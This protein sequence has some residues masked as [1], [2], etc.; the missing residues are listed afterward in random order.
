[1]VVVWSSQA[2]TLFKSNVYADPS[3][4]QSWPACNPQIFFKWVVSF[5]SRTQRRGITNLISP[6]QPI[7]F[8]PPF[9]SPSP[10]T[11]VAPRSSGKIGGGAAVA[12]VFGMTPRESLAVG[13]LMNTRG[14]VEL[15]ILNIGLDAGVLTEVILADLAL[16]V[17]A[18]RVHG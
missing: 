7:P 12:R 15:I 4:S 8:P 17:L 9:L 11:H 1:M 10:P 2:R 5:H 14:L 16:R 6:R 18:S 13:V 3:N